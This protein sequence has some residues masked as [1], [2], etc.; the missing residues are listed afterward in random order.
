MAK[1]KHSKG[2][3]Q[4]LREQRWLI[5][6]TLVLSIICAIL[7]SQT[8][9][10]L[11]LAEEAMLIDG[12]IDSLPQMV[13]EISNN[14][15]EKEAGFTSDY[16]ARGDIAVVLFDLYDNPDQ[17][18]LT[19]LKDAV[20]ALDV[21]IADEA[22]NVVTTTRD[23][24]SSKLTP[25]HMRAI[26]ASE[27]KLVD[28]NN[29]SNDE[30]AR[31]EETL[32]E[33]VAT[34]HD[35]TIED[36][37]GDE[38]H[39]DVDDVSSIIAAD[40]FYPMVYQ[41]KVN[42]GRTLI[43][44]F[45]H[46]ASLSVQ[47]EQAA[48]SSVLKRLLAGLDAY[49]FVYRTDTEDAY[50]YPISSFT[51]EEFAQIEKE[52]DVALKGGDNTL[53]V[54]ELRVGQAKSELRIADLLG[55]KYLFAIRDMADMM[56]DQ[57][58]GDYVMVA[59]SVNSFL[60]G[61]LYTSIAIGIFV[62]CGLGFLAV[63]ARRV[64]VR[65]HVYE[66]EDLKERR[67]V[68][69]ERCLVGIAIVVISTLLF[70]PMLTSLESRASTASITKS[71]RESLQYEINYHEDLAQSTLKENKERSVRQA[72]ALARILSTRPAL[73]THQSLVKLA[74]IVDAEYLMLFDREGK[75]ICASNTYM[76]VT[77][78]TDTEDPTSVYQSVL[79]GRPYVV[80]E[81]A[82]DEALGI[83]SHTVASLVTDTEG[84]P[85]GILVM[86][87]DDT[88]VMNAIQRD[89]LAGVVNGFAT[90]ENQVALVANGESGEILAHSDSSYI[91]HLASELID[92]NI[93][94]KNFEGFSWYSGAYS[95]VSENT[96]EDQSVFMVALDAFDDLM[97]KANLLYIIPP[98]LVFFLLYFF[99]ALFLIAKQ[100][101]TEDEISSENPFAIFAYGYVTY[102][103]VFALVASYLA[104]RKLWPSFG[105]VFSNQW[106]RGVNLFSTISA[107]FFIGIV[108][109][110]AFLLR[111]ILVRSDE[112]A[113][114]NTRTLIRLAHSLAGYISAIVML[115]GVLSMFGVDT[116]TLLASAGIVSIAIGMGAKDLVTDV[117][118]GIFL[119]F[120]GTI[121]VGDIVEIGTYKGRV[122]DMGIRTC[123]ITNDFNEVKIINN[124]AVSNVVN[125]SFSMTKTKIEFEVTQ[126]IAAED[127]DELFEGYIA[128]AIEVVP[129]VADTIVYKGIV[130]ATKHNYIVRIVFSCNEADR[131]DFTAKLTA[132]IKLKIYEERKLR[133]E[134]EKKQKRQEKLQRKKQLVSWTLEHTEQPSPET[135]ST[136]ESSAD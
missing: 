84:L 53:P 132:A 9:L 12:Y 71:K 131:S 105:F 14:T 124:S 82:V 54:D 55:D 101:S 36:L 125:K 72:N 100:P 90:L 1:K 95:F 59:V 21:S 126:L 23:D 17:G 83:T 123:S 19:E 25:S 2:I 136:S 50:G 102:F 41:A 78:G 28:F 57:Y 60:L 65:D 15:A 42:D 45:D 122:T 26:V 39:V 64:A 34:V 89:S 103:V 48:M 85:D 96:E 3:L 91:G 115:F 37:N 110:I 66:I 80:T 77:V 73:R 35:E 118:A 43:V 75:E 97:A 117:L 20:N 13:E 22:G 129:E 107:L 63:Y 18:Q 113:S 46:T 76:G 67:S 99:V 52:L 87:V 116:A 111:T 51:E 119:I 62:A 61:M 86:A 133:K 70:I 135:D 106:S 94:G 4:V 114:P 128:S 30:E 7:T 69:R 49:A 5:I 130:D 6:I 11:S 58:A 81:P 109:A 38:S 134:Q 56:G 8:L 31:L 120:E 108:L 44:E 121:H 93:V 40:I 29:I 24:Q 74:S 98:L 68:L 112:S 32:G 16:I 33:E 88:F 47:A 10:S 92:P 104:T 79:Y 127:I 27:N